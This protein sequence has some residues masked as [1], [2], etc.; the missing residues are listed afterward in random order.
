MKIEFSVDLSDLDLDI[1]RLEKA[2]SEE[3][4]TTAYKIERTSKEL[5]PVET[6]TLRRSITVEGSHLEFD[7][8][9]NVEYA[10]YMEYGTSPHI[11]EGNPYLWWE[12]ANHPVRRVRHTGTKPYLYITTSF[13]E[14]TK[15][16]DT[17][18]AEI[19]GEVL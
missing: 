15:T 10:H 12:G 19:I 3:I 2:I 6:G 16:L 1:N 18:I 7:V 17:R 11:I 13:D 14:H 8:F 9:T 4:E 5:V